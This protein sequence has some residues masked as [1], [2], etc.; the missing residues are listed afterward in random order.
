M[1]KTFY[2]LYN[3]FSLCKKQ[4]LFDA[5]GTV[6]SN[7]HEYNDYVRLLVINVSSIIVVKIGYWTMQQMKTRD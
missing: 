2:Q 3:W 4:L 5:T 7:R 1:L 6:I